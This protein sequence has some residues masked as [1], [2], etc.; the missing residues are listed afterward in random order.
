MSS[1]IPEEQ[2]KLVKDA[3]FNGRKLEAIKLYKEFTSA[4]LREA[5]IAVE[6]LE[7]ELRKYSPEK[8]SSAPGAG[9]KGCR[10]TAVLICLFLAAVVLWLIKK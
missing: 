2:L 3:I 4:G 5:K 7:E 1:Q 9:A 6:E 10:R 8:F